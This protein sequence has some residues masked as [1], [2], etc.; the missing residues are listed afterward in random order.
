MLKRFLA[1]SLALTIF[2]VGYLSFAPSALADQQNQRAAVLS[3]AK[4]DFEINLYP[5]PDS[6]IKRLGYGLSGDTVKILEQVSNN[7]GYSW[8]KV[9]FDNP[10]NAEGWVKSDYISLVNQNPG[11]SKNGYLG[12][13]SQSQGNQRQYNK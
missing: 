11:Q 12:S 3:A 9:R 8:Y 13:Q 6:K 7:S 10:P 1:I 4:A 2:L 5:Q